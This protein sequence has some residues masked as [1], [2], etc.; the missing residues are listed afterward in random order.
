M[1]DGHFK[2]SVVYLCEYN[3][4]GSLGFVI[5]KTQGLLLRDIFPH[6][7]N[8][9]FPLFEGGPVSPNQLF[10][11]HTLGL[12]LKDSQHVIDDVYW[13]GN[14]F[15]LTELIEKGEVSSNQIR[16]YI[17]YSGWDPEQL[18]DEVNRGMWFTKPAPYSRL[19]GI[20]P[21]ELW[22]EELVRIKPGFKA[23]TDYAFDPSLN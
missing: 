17:G 18:A 5:N 12:K 14:F 13:G 3:S 2:R 15:E 4:Q 22:G 8:G 16:F 19:V 23:F 1:Q 7:K 20:A 11:T 9:N 21:E 6:L 10:Y